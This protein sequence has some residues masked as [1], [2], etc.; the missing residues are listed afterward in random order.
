M[1]EY[2]PIVEKLEGRMD[3]RR[4]GSH[5]LAFSGAGF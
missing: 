4:P 1:Q 2:R 3:R 5:R